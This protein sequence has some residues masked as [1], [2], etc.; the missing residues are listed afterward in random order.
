MMPDEPALQALPDHRQVI[1]AP[2]PEESEIQRRFSIIP[3]NWHEVPSAQH[4]GMP[5]A[6][7]QWE[8][9]GAIKGSS[10][11]TSIRKSSTALMRNGR[12]R[13]DG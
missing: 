9:D 13:R 6:K 2:S 8:S 7:L 3:Q 5:M 1:P 10:L 11:T 4:R 12:F